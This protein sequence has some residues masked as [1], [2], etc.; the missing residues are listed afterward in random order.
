MDAH[1]IKIWRMT[2]AGVLTG[3]FT[4]P[5]NGIYNNGSG[6]SIITTGPDGNLWFGEY[7]C[8]QVG[9]ITPAGTITEFPVPTGNFNFSQ[10][11]TT[12]PDGALWF[13]EYLANKIGRI[14]TTGTIT[15]F[16]VPSGGAY[17]ATHITAGPD[18]NLWFT[19]CRCSPGASGPTNIGRITPSGTITEFPL[20]AGSTPY[21]ITAGPDGNLWFAEPGT[22]KIGRITPAGVIRE[23]LIPTANSGAY[24]ITKGPDGNL[25]FTER[26]T[27][28]IGRI[29]PAG[30]VTEFF[31]SVGGGVPQGITTGPDGNLWITDTN[32]IVKATILNTPP[33]TLTIYPATGGNTG[34]VTVQVFGSG[35]Q[36]GATV[37][38]T[39]IGADIIGS[40]VNVTNSSTL[41]ATFNL[42]GATPGVRNVVITNPDNT[43]ATLTIGFAVEQ[44]GEPEIAVDFIGRNQIRIGREQAYYAVIRNQG[45]V[46]APMVVGTI[47]SLGDS[48]FNL[49]SAAGSAQAVMSKLSL[50]TLNQP[51]PL[52]SPLTPFY[53]GPVN[54]SSF[55]SVPIK[56]L[57]PSPSCSTLQ[58]FGHMVQSLDP[59]DVLK[60]ASDA[61]DSYLNQLYVTKL[62]NLKYG[63]K[64][65]FQ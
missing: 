39:G 36:S 11:I 57:E 46:D 5:C 59:C 45:S 42:T 41:S 28:N 61:A 20:T 64:R 56:V 4:I 16:P 33:G 52:A 50:N 19:V 44:G 60:A 27:N 6:A 18:G 47:G 55:K 9:R 22:N 48:V 3:E 49:S 23:F 7:F 35:F 31:V 17:G 30:V 51:A 2:P 54:A 62:A 58:G 29:T 63:R 14:T 24:S 12:G 1:G 13:T 37:K 32:T 15:E 40:T 25:W 34:N 26:F 43:T 53:V 21:G 8:N 10:G 38:L 65:L